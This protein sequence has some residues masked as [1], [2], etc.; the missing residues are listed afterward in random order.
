[1]IFTDAEEDHDH[2]GM[3]AKREPLGIQR[4]RH[5]EMVPINQPSPGNVSSF[6]Y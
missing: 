5:N 2:E 3:G 4:K 1:M 6:L